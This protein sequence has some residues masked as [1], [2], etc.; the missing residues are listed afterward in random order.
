M[1]KRAFAGT[2]PGQTVKSGVAVKAKNFGNL[3]PNTAN[4]YR[5]GVYEV[6]AAVLDDDG[7]LVKPANQYQNFATYDDGLK[8]LIWDVKSKQH[9][10]GLSSSAVGKG[11]EIIDV[12]KKYAPA[13]DRNNPEGYTNHIVNFVNERLG[14]TGEDAFTSKSPASDLPTELLVE[15]I[16]SK[17]IFL[18][19]K[20]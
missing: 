5:S 20:T 13:A 1:G 12:M 16:I 9:L 14:L 18:Y 3:L 2:R 17:E 8:G 7:N 6:S 15:A 11:A 19:T 4:P 10:D